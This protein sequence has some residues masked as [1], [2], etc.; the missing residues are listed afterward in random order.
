MS[1]FTTKGNNDVVQP[2]FWPQPAFLRDQYQPFTSSRHFATY[3]KALVP[4][5]HNTQH[6]QGGRKP[7]DPYFGLQL[8]L[9]HSKIVSVASRFSLEIFANMDL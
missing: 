8:R 9:L 1:D 2:F 3:I 4:R 6:A 5:F 7:Q